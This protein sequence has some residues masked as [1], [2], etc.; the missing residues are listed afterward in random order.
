[1]VKFSEQPKKETIITSNIITQQNL[2]NQPSLPMT[3]R[4]PQSF[5][6]ESTPQL[7]MNINSCK[8]LFINGNIISSSYNNIN[9]RGNTWQQRKNQWGYIFIYR[10]AIGSV[11]I[12][13]LFHILWIEKH[14]RHILKLYVRK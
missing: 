10:S 8:P 3:N 14:K 1:M 7:S 12:A 2:V 5:P 9:I 13:I 6:T 11:T 4:I